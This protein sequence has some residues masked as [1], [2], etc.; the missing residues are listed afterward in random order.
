MPFDGVHCESGGGSE[1]DSLTIIV[2]V[3]GVCLYQTENTPFDGV[4]LG[5]RTC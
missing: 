2:V 3:T 4:H 5:P 1:R